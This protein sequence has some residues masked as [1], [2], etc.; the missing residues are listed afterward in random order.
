MGGRLPIVRRRESDA[1]VDD[2]RFDKSFDLAPRG[3]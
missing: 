2:I 1:M 3:S